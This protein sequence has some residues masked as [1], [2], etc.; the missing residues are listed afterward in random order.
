M[1][2]LTGGCLTEGD[3]G[4]GVLKMLFAQVAGMFDS[5]AYWCLQSKVASSWTLWDC[6]I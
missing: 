6:S 2:R 3:C 5:T 4:V 1:S